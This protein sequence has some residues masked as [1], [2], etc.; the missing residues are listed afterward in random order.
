MRPM[1]H[2]LRPRPF[3]LRRP[4]SI[5]ELVPSATQ[6]AAIEA[7][8][9]RRMLVLGDAGHGKT[10]LVLLRL[11]ELRRRKLAAGGRFRARVIVPTEGLRAFIDDDLARLGLPREEV[12]AETYERWALRAAR[13]AFV[14]L[15]S[16]TSDD[17][18]PAVIRLKRDPALVEAIEILSLRAPG[19]VDDD[20]EAPAVE[21]RA[22][23]TWGDLQHLF[24]DRALLEGVL[25]CARGRVPR[26]AI[27]ETLAHTKVQFAWRA[28]QLFAHVTDATKMKTVD[29]AE[30][31]EGTPMADAGSLD[32][33]DAAV[34]FAL[35]FSRARRQGARAMRPPLLDCLVLDEAQELAP[36]ELRLLGRSLRK[37]GEGASLIVAGDGEQQLDPSA[38]FP[39]WTSA[40]EALRAR[41]HD[42]VTLDHGFRCPIRVVALAR[43]VRDG[44]APSEDEL[45][46]LSRTHE[47][48][49]ETA[50]FLHEEL[51]HLREHDGAATIALLCHDDELLR[52]L[53]ARLL[54]L[55]IVVPISREGRFPKRGA[56]LARI[57]EVRGLEFDFVVV[58]AIERFDD[59]PAE[60]RRL[61]V[62]M[63]RTRHQLLTIR[64]ARALYS[65]SGGRARDRGDALA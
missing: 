25:T 45:R 60:R 23:A 21:T 39:G 1:R 5:A 19:L 41:E 15:P 58:P 37:L 34:M 63:T 16:R 35:D 53:H 64:H 55:S 14:D 50:R 9:S 20:E 8:P 24:G 22:H 46:G 4:L 62:A 31:D 54:E 36:L 43:A 7:D 32:A 51:T 17:A 27:D 6:R 42:I 30:L 49:D 59:T 26:H 3:D 57:E 56:F 2:V 28:E 10:T 47:D 38:S 11:A 61:Y 18:T 40:M 13:R 48:I 44:R 52:A 33:E 29:G 12:R 65:G